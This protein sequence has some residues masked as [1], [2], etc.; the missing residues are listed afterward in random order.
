VKLPGGKL[1]TDDTE[2]AQAAGS[3]ARALRLSPPYRAEA[4][5]RN[6]LW[7]IAARRIETAELDPDPGG[8]DIELVW[9]GFERSVR[10]DDTPTLSSIPAL[11]R[12][13][14]ARS[15]TYVATA[16]RLDGAVWEV[17][18]SPL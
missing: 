18:I 9:D 15:A 1:V 5:L 10:I 4:L 8:A 3:L 16:A 11:E 14:A 6:G 12:L 2:A 17:S 7:V 13:A